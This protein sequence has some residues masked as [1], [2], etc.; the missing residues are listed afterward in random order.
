[1]AP[2]ILV[3]HLILALAVIGLVLIQRSEGGG[4]GGMGGGNLGGLSTA[5]GTA[6][7]L[8]RLTAICAAGFFITSITLGMMASSSSQANKGILEDVNAKTEIQA[9]V[10]DGTA[11]EGSQKVIP[12]EDMTGKEVTIPAEE[13]LKPVE[14]A[15]AEEV[16]PEVVTPENTSVV[17]EKEDVGDKSVPATEMPAKSE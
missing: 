10:H 9:P 7:A 15:P 2:V 11:S 17:P 5:R 13:A 12:I 1:M 8:T 3:I 6:N 16:K 4:L 14:S